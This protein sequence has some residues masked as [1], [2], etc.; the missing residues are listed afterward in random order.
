MEYLRL[1]LGGPAPRDPE[2]ADGTG[3]TGGA[4]GTGGTGGADGTG[5]TGS[6]ATVIPDRAQV[7][8][9]HATLTEWL[10]TDRR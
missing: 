5:G 10:N 9:M 6:Q 7:E 3:G 4:D 2:D 1:G 8:L